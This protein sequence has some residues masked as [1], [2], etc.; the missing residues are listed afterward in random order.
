MQAGKTVRYR[1][2][3]GRSVRDDE[4]LAR[5][6]ALAIPPAWTAVWICPWA[7]AHIQ[8]TGRDAKGRNRQYRYHAKWAR[9]A[10]TRPSMSE[11]LLLGVPSPGSAGKRRAT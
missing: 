5:I 4:T 8:A 11:C 9:R 3:Q 2:S 7:N 6:K 1:D 10:A